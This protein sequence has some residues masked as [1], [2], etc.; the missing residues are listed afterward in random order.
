MAYGVMP[1]LCGN[2][3]R[4]KATADNDF[5]Y[6]PAWRCRQVDFGEANIW[7]SS[8]YL[9]SLLYSSHARAAFG[10][11]LNINRAAFIAFTGDK[12]NIGHSYGGAAALPV[13]CRGLGSVEHFTG[14]DFVGR[15]FDQF[16]W[17]VV[18][19]GAEKPVPVLRIRVWWRLHDRT[20]RRPRGAY[21][22]ID[23]IG[24]S[25]GQPAAALEPN[26][27]PRRIY[28]QAQ[29]WK[30]RKPTGLMEL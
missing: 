18:G 14:N 21:S 15:P 16:P 23:G 24:Q 6:T 12:V 29:I 11:D 26:S 27:E 10:F 20:P 17:P 9:T 8:L 28:A 13:P 1:S 30:M 5:K 4:I 19:A 22:A 2:P 7:P 3:W 25:D